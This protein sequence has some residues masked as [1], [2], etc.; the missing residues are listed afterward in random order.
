[1][2]IKRRK[3]RTNTRDGHGGLASGQY[4]AYG[5][6]P[7]APNNPTTGTPLVSK[8]VTN[9]PK[10]QA[11]GISDKTVRRSLWAGSTMDANRIKGPEPIQYEDRGMLGTLVPAARESVDQ[12]AMRSSAKASLVND[13][14]GSESRPRMS[15]GQEAQRKRIEDAR[16]A[17]DLTQTRARH[18]E[19]VRVQ[20]QTER[21]VAD[22]TGKYNVES[23]RVEGD[24]KLGVAETRGAALVEGQRVANQGGVDVA[25]VQGQTAE[26]VAGINAESAEKIEKAR[27]EISAKTGVAWDIVALEQG[28]ND[29]GVAKAPLYFLRNTQSGALFP[30]NQET[31]QI[32]Q[33]DV[34]ASISGQGNPQDGNAFTRGIAA[35]QDFATDLIRRPFAG[36]G[37]AQGGT[38]VGPGSGRQEAA[39]P[40]QRLDA[41]VARAK[42]GGEQLTPDEIEFLRRR[43]AS[44]SGQ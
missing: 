20:G 12:E 27:A 35:V 32:I 17:R 31:G 10:S 42:A 43:L 39:T 37:G 22:T 19:P 14:A 25:S 8:V 30:V 24:A 2:A 28:E 5:E 15:P 23:K 1:M 13:F 6:R 9:V 16:T 26:S 38:L 29:K 33:Q 4:Y 3:N 40:R 21:A 7:G 44:S 41:A 11:G 18:V 36:G 34:S